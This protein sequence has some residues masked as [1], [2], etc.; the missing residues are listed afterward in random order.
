[1]LYEN[2]NH[3]SSG[4]IVRPKQVVDIPISL[5]KS[6]QGRYFVGQTETLKVG[7]GMNAWA[8]LVNPRDSN[9]NLYA[10][11][12][13]I[14]NFSD[15][16][17]TAQVWLNITFP[18]TSKISSKISSTNTALRPLPRNEVDIRYIE[19]TTEVPKDGVNVYDRIVPP[20]TTLVSEEDGK[21]I[22]APDGDY[23]IIIKSSSSNFN[24]VIVAFGFWE[25]FRH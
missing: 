22:E 25:K 2:K 14:S 23:V 7:N 20:K 16:Y 10:N 17:L 13:T 15:E 6:M 18:E 11:V 4:K 24:K 8:G 5:F 21:F 19:S 3:I 1:M 9:V 12:F